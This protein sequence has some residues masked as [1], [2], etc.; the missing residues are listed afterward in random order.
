[1]GRQEVF[2]AIEGSNTPPTINE[3]ARLLGKRKATVNR[4]I[5]QMIKYGEAKASNEG[6]KGCRVI[7][8]I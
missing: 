2:D 1:M 5:N 4:I 6:V 7:T 8:L 3:V